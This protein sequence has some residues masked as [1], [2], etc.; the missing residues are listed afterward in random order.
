MT[1]TDRDKKTDRYGSPGTTSVNISEVDKPAETGPVAYYGCPFCD[2]EVPVTESKDAER[3]VRVHITRE[4]RGKHGG[5]NAFQ[6][7]VHVQG[8]DADGNEV[9]QTKTTDMDSYEGTAT[10]ELVPADLADREREILEAIIKN[11]SADAGDIAEI[12]YGD[13]SQTSYVNR[14]QRK[15]IKSQQGFENNT[16][17][18]K[19]YDDLT[20]KQR[21]VIDATLDLGRDAGAYKISDHASEEYLP[22]DE[23]VSHQTVYDTFDDYEYVYEHRKARREARKDRLGPK[24]GTPETDET[25]DEPE[26]E[27]VVEEEP[28]PEPEEKPTP[29][30]DE[31]DDESAE[32]AETVAVPRELLRDFARR[33]DVLMDAATQQRDAAPRDSPMKLNAEGRIDVLN[34]VE[35]FLT[36]VADETTSSAIRSDE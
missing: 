5:K 12:V 27:T 1:D 36:D 21:A 32:R 10:T 24:A 16:A 15:Y 26:E 9:K 14:T 31:S 20:E 18:E 6:D 30:V 35:E 34:D 22:G 28:E 8:Y 23:T 25:V 7:L 4:T 3:M 13:R 2:Y 17:K 11:P 33:A 19:S 29:T